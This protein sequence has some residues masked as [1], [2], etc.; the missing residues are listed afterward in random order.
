[1]D[2]LVFVLGLIAGQ[3][4]F[5]TFT[6]N[7]GKEHVVEAVADV[8]GNVT[9]NASNLP[10]GFFIVYGG[11]KTVTWKQSGCDNLC[12]MP[13]RGELNYCCITLRPVDRVGDVGEPITEI[14]P[15]CEEKP[16]TETLVLDSINFVCDKTEGIISGAFTV[17]NGSGN[18]TLQSYYNSMW[19]GVKTFT[20]AITDGTLPFSENIGKPQPITVDIRVIDNDTLL[21]SNTLPLIITSCDGE[22]VL[23]INS[24]SNQ[25]C[26]NGVI[27]AL[28]DVTIQNWSGVS[29]HLFYSIDGGLI[30]NENPAGIYNGT[31]TMDLPQA[32]NGVNGVQFYLRDAAN[33]FNSPIYTTNIIACSVE[34]LLI[35]AVGSETCVLGGFLNVVFDFAITNPA[36]DVRFLLGGAGGAGATDMGSAVNGIN[37]FNCSAFAGM[38]NQEARLYDTISGLYSPFFYH[39]FPACDMPPSAVVIRNL[40]PTGA[41]SFEL[42]T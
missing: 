22:E 33:N 21:A 30:F 14:V 19:N 6:D 8:N 11:V 9:I 31:F 40:I 27:N 12:F 18:Y 2:A 1:M 15:C 5:F 17:A 24:I 3:T 23:N 10:D 41:S 35:N 34:N 36:G 7:H 39:T 42:L 37:T 29:V 16:Q 13:C 20:G 38:I 4:Y 25:V 32:V 28:M 26:N